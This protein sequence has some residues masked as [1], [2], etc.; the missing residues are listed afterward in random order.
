MKPTLQK[1]VLG[2]MKT[3]AFA[4]YSQHTRCILG[5]KRALQ[6]LVSTCDTRRVTLSTTPSCVPSRAWLPGG[7]NDLRNG[8]VGNTEAELAPEL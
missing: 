8:N 5:L 3:L 2:K 1:N 7:C 6:E 4:G